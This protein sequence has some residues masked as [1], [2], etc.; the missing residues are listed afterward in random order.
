L[1]ESNP[2]ITYA[3]HPDATPAG[4]RTALVEVYAFVLEKHR[5]K[6]AGTSGRDDAVVRHKRG[7]EPCR[8][9]TQ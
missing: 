1:S 3:P 5:E 9:T 8:A 6:A 7:G 4:Q 2:R